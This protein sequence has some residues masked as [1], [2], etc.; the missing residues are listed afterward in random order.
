LARIINFKLINTTTK[1]KAMTVHIAN[2]ESIIDEKYFVPKRNAHKGT[3]RNVDRSKKHKIG[4][5]YADC[6][7]IE[8]LAAF[9]DEERTIANKLKNEYEAMQLAT[10]Y[11]TAK[12]ALLRKKG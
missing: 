4:V 11:E 3:G 2:N 8:C 1:D 5:T 9:T 6:T 7:C 10:L 12:R